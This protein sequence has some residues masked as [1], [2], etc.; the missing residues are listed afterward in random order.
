MRKFA[1]AVAG[2]LSIGA[3]AAA[4][5]GAQEPETTLSVEAK[6]TPNKAGT[7]KKP[8]GV[9][10]SVEGHLRTVEGVEKPIVQ[11]IVTLFPHG[12]NYNGGKYPKC[13]YNTLERRT[14]AGCPKESIMGG[15][16]AMAYADTVLTKAKI[17]IVNGG[18]D[19]SFGFVTMYNPAF[20][21]APVVGD[22]ERLND[23]KWKYRLT[24][25][26]P[27]SLQVVAGV[28][29]AAKDLYMTFGG[30]PYAKNWIESTSCPKSKKWPYHVDLYMSSGKTLAYDNSVPCR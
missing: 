8:Q 23:P 13:T 1:V 27:T 3:V 25:K 10:I 22:I 4:L 6:V 20:V 21:Q 19:R 18:A 12:G 24:V 15:G 16:Y 30:K 9:K 14:P 7:P 17:T 29:I 26:I 28:P 2:V 11:K 5:A